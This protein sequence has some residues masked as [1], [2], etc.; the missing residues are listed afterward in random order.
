MSIAWHQVPASHDAGAARTSLFD[1]ALLHRL[2]ELVALPEDTAAWWTA[3]VHQVDALDVAFWDHR[4]AME[5]ADGI[6]R[7]VVS[8]EPRLAFE[9][10]GC[11]RELERIAAQIAQL[12]LLLASF[13]GLDGGP[14]RAVVEVST[15]AS[16][17]RTH[18]RHVH[19]LL[20]EAYVVDLGASG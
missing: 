1:D 10:R 20:H 8:A 19:A 11:E 9:V 6:F 18:H 15:V 14:A 2:L 17:V 3:L 5:S 13:M 16:A 7:D 12:R 4:A